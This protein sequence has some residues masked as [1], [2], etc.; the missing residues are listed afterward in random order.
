MATDENGQGWQQRLALSCTFEAATVAEEQAHFRR[1]AEQAPLNELRILLSRP[2]GQFD[3]D[4]RAVMRGVLIERETKNLEESNRR[5]QRSVWRWGLLQQVIA[6]LALLVVGTA[7][8][9]WLSC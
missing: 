1:E 8:G 7:L 2:G 6:G 9:A 3:H 5:I 4:A